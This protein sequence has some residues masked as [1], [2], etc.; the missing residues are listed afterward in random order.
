MPSQFSSKFGT[1]VLIG[2]TALLR[3]RAE[4]LLNLEDTRCI[5]ICDELREELE[6][7]AAA[8]KASDEAFLDKFENS[9]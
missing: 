9:L 4:A 3:L 8:P 2:D 1:A 7:I 6:R 5:D